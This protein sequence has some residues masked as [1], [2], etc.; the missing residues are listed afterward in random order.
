M[1]IIMFV[2]GCVY[3]CDYRILEYVSGLAHHIVALTNPQVWH[4]FLLYLSQV[5]MFRRVTGSWR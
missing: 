1:Y 3:M 4:T 2:F 5:I